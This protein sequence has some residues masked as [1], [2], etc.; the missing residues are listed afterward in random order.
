M[1]PEEVHHMGRTLSRS[2]T[3]SHR[4]LEPHVAEPNLGSCLM[5]GTLLMLTAP[6]S[7][8]V[9]TQETGTPKTVSLSLSGV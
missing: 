7:R 5:K 4:G 9:Q 8:E 1:K 3:D 2:E 6:G